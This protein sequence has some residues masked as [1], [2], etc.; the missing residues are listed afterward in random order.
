MIRTICRHRVISSFLAAV[1]FGL[2]F[3]GVASA[4]SQAA[5]VPTVNADIGACSADFTVSQR[6]NHPLF[7][8]QITVKISY[9]FL[10]T[11]K[12]D[13]QI[14][15]NSEGKA[16]FEG[17]PSKVHN[18]PLRFTIKHNGWTKT[19]DYWPR[20]RCHAKYAVIMSTH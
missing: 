12:M 19:V 18:P 9:G 8:A 2:A 4:R 5:E 7:N 20:V 10:G 14:G 13:L 17:L 6:L 11:K 15:T 1:V 16:R 3:A